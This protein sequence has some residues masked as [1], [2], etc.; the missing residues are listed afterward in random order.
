[1]HEQDSHWKEEYENERERLSKTYKDKLQSKLD[2]AQKVYE[3]KLKNEFLQQSISPQNSFASSV[4]DQV[5]TEREGRLGKL[6]ELSSS[7]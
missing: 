5:E 3:Q 4:R 1:M 6:N 7:V 2:A